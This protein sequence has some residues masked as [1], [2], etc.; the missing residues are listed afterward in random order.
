[1]TLDEKSHS[2]RS[3]N[4]KDLEHEV[5]LEHEED[6]TIE[7]DLENEKDNENDLYFRAYLLK[8]QDH[9]ICEEITD[10]LAVNGDK[11]DQMEFENQKRNISEIGDNDEKEKPKIIKTQRRKVGFLAQKRKSG[12]VDSSAR[13][14]Q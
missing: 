1:M 2:G 9:K 13:G 11:L 6:L 12:P 8:V 7:D 3:R 10:D 5:Y 14:R 4:E